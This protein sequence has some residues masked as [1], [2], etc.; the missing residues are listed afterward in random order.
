MALERPLGPTAPCHADI[1]EVTTPAR[2]SISSRVPNTMALSSAATRS[3]CTS[4][5]RRDSWTHRSTLVGEPELAQTVH[6]DPVVAEQIVQ[7]EPLRR[8]HHG[9]GPGSTPAA[10]PRT[11]PIPPRQGETTCSDRRPGR[12]ER[13]TGR[14]Q[15]RPPAA[16]SS[17]RQTA[18]SWWCGRAARAASALPSPHRTRSRRRQP[19]RRSCPRARPRYAR[20]PCRGAPRAGPASARGWSAG[21]CRDRDKC[22]RSV[23]GPVKSARSNCRRCQDSCD[24]GSNECGGP[25]TRLPSPRCHPSRRHRRRLSRSPARSAEESPPA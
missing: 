22:R 7:R 4:W 6:R 8:V 15:R 10:H 17:R 3:R 16:P 14:L 20:I 13:R 1:A 23:R 12:I 18:H 11:Q 2:S 19:A 25:R 5:R 9:C 21:R 24:D